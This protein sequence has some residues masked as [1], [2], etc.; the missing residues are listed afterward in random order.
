LGKWAT[1]ESKQQFRLWHAFLA[2]EIAAFF[3]FPTRQPL[4][5]IQM[6]YASCP[7]MVR[8][9][10]VVASAARWQKRF[11]QTGKQPYDEDQERL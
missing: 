7:L 3:A 1:I 5:G 11:D 9:R 10:V 4:N 6:G 8:A 2:Q